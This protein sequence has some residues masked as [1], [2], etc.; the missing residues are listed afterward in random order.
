MQYPGVFCKCGSPRRIPWRERIDSL[1]LE[2]SPEPSPASCV[3]AS[4]ANYYP[5]YQREGNSRND[6]RDDGGR[7]TSRR[8][9]RASRNPSRSLSRIHAR[10]Y[11]TSAF[12][13]D[14]TQRV[15][16]NSVRA[17][18]TKRQTDARD[19]PGE[20]P[21]LVTRGCKYAIIRV[22]NVASFRNF[23]PLRSHVESFLNGARKIFNVPILNVQDS[24]KA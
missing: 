24:R 2:R 14:V 23:S 4:L 19:A 17:N 15:V 13:R 5:S 8:G 3:F 1:S 11:V 12:P 9:R 16:V 21:R 6:P 7:A 18:Y 22:Y 20:I 10:V